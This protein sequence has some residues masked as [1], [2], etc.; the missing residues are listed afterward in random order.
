MRVKREREWTEKFFFGIFGDKKSGRRNFRDAY[1]INIVTHL[2]GGRNVTFFLGV[3]F[4]FFG[5]I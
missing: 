1:N 4:L 5:A 2:L 3:G